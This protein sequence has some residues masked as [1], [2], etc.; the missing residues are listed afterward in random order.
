MEGCVNSFMYKIILEI[1]NFA[2]DITIYVNFLNVCGSKQ[3]SF[4]EKL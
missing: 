1:T 3:N 4:P 2:F